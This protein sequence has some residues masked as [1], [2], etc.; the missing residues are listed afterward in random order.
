MS[1]SDISLCD[2]VKEIVNMG[3]RTRGYWR[4]ILLA[5]LSLAF[6]GPWAFDLINVPAEYPCYAPVVRL[7]GEFC[8]VPLLGVQLLSMMFSGLISAS[9][10]LVTGSVGVSDWLRQ[11]VFSLL[12]IL[13]LLPIFSTLLMIL[14]EER[15]R[16]QMFN[17]VAWIVALVYCSLVV[18]SG[19]P[20]MF[21]SLWGVW[22]YLGLSAGSVVLE[23]LA[24]KRGRPGCLGAIVRMVIRA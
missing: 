15:R 2:I 8:G 16:L 21:W 12:G 6:M 3:A 9:K 18:I 17:L 23:V 7:Y 11:I 22:L 20:K 19:Y 4:V 24:L 13:I 1:I 5:L 14:L 10:G